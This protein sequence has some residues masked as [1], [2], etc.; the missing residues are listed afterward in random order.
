M[1]TGDFEGTA[2]FNKKMVVQYRKKKIV[3]GKVITAMAKYN[4]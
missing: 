3:S 1:I 4:G 2:E